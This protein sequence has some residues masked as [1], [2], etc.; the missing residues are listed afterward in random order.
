VTIPLIDTGAFS[1]PPLYRAA[2]QAEV[3]AAGQ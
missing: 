3:A 1:T 2:A